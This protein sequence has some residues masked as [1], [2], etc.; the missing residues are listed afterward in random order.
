MIQLDSYQSLIVDARL[1]L[2]DWHPFRVS[3]QTREQ[4]LKTAIMLRKRNG[5]LPDASCD[6][7]Y[8][9]WRA[10]VVY[11][12]KNELFYLIGGMEKVLALNFIEP[13]ESKVEVLAKHIR[14]TMKM[15]IDRPTK[16]G[17]DTVRGQ[18]EWLLLNKHCTKMR[19]H[20]CKRKLL[21]ILPKNW[22]DIIWKIAETSKYRKRSINPRLFRS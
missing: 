9:K 14:N 19:P 22:M 17:L 3:S 12:R 20:L 18:G 8:Y 1:L 15:V 6:Q 16:S 4:Y 5:R 7:T 10:A 13:L 2:N 11:F 21:G